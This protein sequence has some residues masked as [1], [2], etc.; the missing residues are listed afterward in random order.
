MG[1]DMFGGIGCFVL[2]FPAVCGECWLIVYV[3]GMLGAGIGI[4]YSVGRKAVDNIKY[5]DRVSPETA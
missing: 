5:V 1:L 3:I 2:V 4:G